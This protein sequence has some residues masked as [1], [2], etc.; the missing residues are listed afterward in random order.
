MRQR[1]FVEQ[2]RDD[3]EAFARLLD[4]M[5]RGAGVGS[6]PALDLPAGYRRVCHH[7]TLARSRRYGPALIRRLE[8][9][10]WRGHELLYRRRG[11]ARW[12][13]LNFVAAG[14]P[15]AL[16]RQR[17]Y[18]LGAAAMFLLPALIMGSACHINPEIIY[19]VMSPDA[20]ADMETM[21][22]PGND[23]IGRS[24]GRQAESDF[25]M[26][27]YYIYNNIGIGFRTFA[28]G[29]LLGAGTAFLLLFNGLLIGGIA[30][31]LTR[32]GYVDTFWPFVAGHSALEL[33]AIVVCGAAGL[34]LAHGLLAPGQRTRLDA[35]R[36]R[37]GQA[38]PLVTGAALML[39]LAAF[40]EAF[41]SSSGVAPDIKLLAGGAFWVL[42]LAYFTL[43]GR[44]HGS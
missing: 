6:R 35:L 27:G 7:Y 18:L 41:W 19:T 31:H 5:E 14:F 37:A 1:R 36:E 20:A 22:D 38:V 21:Y 10:V 9:L 2:Y 17:R 29:I 32:L 15:R 34:M 23:R 8:D 28:G 25:V 40:V 13:F 26:F 16:R 44:G 24:E 11:A 4:A 3:W 33:T 42:V 12:R 43:A 39:L 30:G